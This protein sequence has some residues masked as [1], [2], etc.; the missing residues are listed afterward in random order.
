MQTERN[1]VIIIIGYA[2]TDIYLVSALLKQFPDLI[3]IR[4][5]QHKTKNLRYYFGKLLSKG[6][7]ISLGI[8]MVSVYLRA[9]IFIEKA[10]GKSV[11]TQFGLSKPVFPENA[12]II[13]CKNL[14]ELCEISESN[15][16]GTVII[17]QSLRLND[18]FFKLNRNVL[19]IV[20]GRYPKYIGDTS[21]FWAKA[22]ATIADYCFTIIQRKKYFGNSVPLAYCPIDINDKDSIRSLRIRGILASSH[23]LVKILNGTETLINYHEKHHESQIFSTP[24]ITDYLRVTVLR[25][26]IKIPEY[27]KKH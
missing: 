9:E 11:W 14:D 24:T 19:Q 12:I 21:V 17:T 20:G 22:T 16:H 2:M 4:Y 3:I 23:S 26:H 5:R 10:L 15:K 1:P 13:D 6:F 8:K 7:F 18:R 25:R 27:A